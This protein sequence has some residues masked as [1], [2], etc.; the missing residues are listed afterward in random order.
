[1]HKLYIRIPLFFILINS[2]LYSCTEVVDVDV[3]NGG[4]RLVIEASIDWEK[5]TLGQL[6]TIKLSTSTPYFTSN[7]EAPVTGAIV[8]VTKEDDGMQFVF[9]DQNNG[10]Y[11]TTNFV[12][13]L[14]Q[15][16]SLEIIYEDGIYVANETLMS[17]SSITE[18]EQDT[19]SGFS[20]DEIAV[21]IY[22][23]DPVGVENFYLGEFIP[24]HSPLINFQALNDRLTDGNQ[25]FVEYN[26]E[27][28]KAGDLLEISLLG[29]SENYYTY[30]NI[31]EN[32][33][34]DGGPFSTTPVQLVGNCKNQ[35]N[36]NE[37]VLGYFRLSEVDKIIYTIQ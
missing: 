5:G 27:D 14:N 2:L 6:Q 3:P 35:N 17:V 37:E 26:D 13:E 18:I 15:S 1:M 9:T 33:S 30:M 10:N 31:L 8:T 36:L 29:I 34:G 24:S 25:K 11:I 22:F 23:D 7:P 16:Y 28:I 12:P 4:E 32:Q 20:E 21:T 19:S